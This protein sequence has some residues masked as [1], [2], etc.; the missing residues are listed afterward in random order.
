M[1]LRVKVSCDYERM[2]YDPEQYIL[3][4]LY[5]FDSSKPSKPRLLGSRVDEKSG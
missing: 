5:E 2:I 4:N 1:T 3:I